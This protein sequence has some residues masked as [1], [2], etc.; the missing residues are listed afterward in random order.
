MPEVAEPAVC[1]PLEVPFPARAPLGHFVTTEL[2]DAGSG[3]AGAMKVW[4]RVRD[5]D[6][7]RPAILGFIA[8]YVPLSVMRALREVGAGTSLDNTIRIGGRPAFPSPWV[9]LEIFPDLAADG[10][11]HGTARLWST[12][13]ELLGVASQT[14]RLKR[15]PG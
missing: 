4:A 2:R 11:G 10:F 3:P 7:S 13:G 5:H 8:D 12:A 15:F 14:M 1:P 9:L 6:P